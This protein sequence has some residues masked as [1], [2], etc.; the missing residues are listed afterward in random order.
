[1][2]SYLTG[3]IVKQQ[4]LRLD[5][6]IFEVTDACNFN[7]NIVVMVKYITMWMSD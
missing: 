6:I 1:M 2:K 5:K 3:S 4:L 7:V